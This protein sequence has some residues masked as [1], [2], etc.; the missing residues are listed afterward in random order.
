MNRTRKRT[1]NKSR[2]YLNINARREGYRIKEATIQEM[3]WIFRIY[4]EDEENNFFLADPKH[5]QKL[6]SFAKNAKSNPEMI[7][8]HKKTYSKE[9]FRSI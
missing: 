9:I 5:F 8:G 7:R 1:T 4:Q 2:F 3:K 6:K